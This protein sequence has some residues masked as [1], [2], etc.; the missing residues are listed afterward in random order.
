MLVPMT[1]ITILAPRSQL[2]AVIAELHR[3]GIVHL[4]GTARQD[5]GMTPAGP[6]PDSGPRMADLRVEAD[7][8]GQLARLDGTAASAVSAA[9]WLRPV[10]VTAKKGPPGSPRVCAAC[11]A[12][13]SRCSPNTRSPSGTATPLPCSCRWRRSW[14]C[15]ARATWPGWASPS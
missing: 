12:G 7:G 1:P 8:L 9:D 3:Q 6:G 11:S 13:S 15:S 4:T 2:P 10:T 5:P 14:R